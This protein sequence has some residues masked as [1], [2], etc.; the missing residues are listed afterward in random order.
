M[1]IRL[2][3]GRVNFYR[4]CS[5]QYCWEIEI[6]LFVGVGTARFTSAIANQGVAAVL[7]VVIAGLANYFLQQQRIR[8]MQQESA[9][10]EREKRTAETLAAGQTRRLADIYAASG[11]ALEAEGDYA[12]ALLWFSKALGEEP[13]DSARAGTHRQRLVS[14][15]QRM[16]SMPLLLAHAGGVNSAAFSHDGRRMVTASDDRTAQVWDAATGEPIGPPLN[17]SNRVLHAELSADGG[18]V[19]TLNASGLA[20]LWSQLGSAPTAASLE[21][22][23]RFTLVAFSPNGRQLMT[24]TDGSEAL[25]WETS[26]RRWRFKLKHAGRILCAAFSADGRFVATGGQDQSARVWNTDTG[27]LITTAMEPEGEV[28]HLAFSPDGRRLATAAGARARIWS[29]SGGDA[30]LFLLH[31]DARV[32]S[33]GFSPEGSRILTSS[34]D[35]SA[36]Q[37]DAITGEALGSPARHP[38]AVRQAVFSPDGRCIATAC[39][40]RVQVWN[41]RT[42]KLIPPVFIHNAPV[43]EVRFSPSGHGLLTASADGTARWF[44]LEAGLE[45]PSAEESNRPSSTGRDSGPKV[46][47]PRGALTDEEWARWAQACSGRHVS[48]AEQIEPLPAESLRK[49]W[50]LLREKSPAHFDSPDRVLWH[51]RAAEACEEAG[52]WFGANFHWAQAL[53]LRPGEARFRAGRERAA[54]QQALLEA[55]ASAE[56]GTRNAERGI[57]DSALTVPRSAFPLAARAG[58]LDLSSHYNAAL[59]KT[60]LPNRLA[61][62][63]PLQEAINAGYVLY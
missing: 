48:S 12:G 50:V 42:F 53:T 19:L 62:S 49:L 18:R 55:K 60:W 15:R 39:G 13:S 10:R 7:V 37:W 33:L 47:D 16:P 6:P 28:T 26:S 23:G 14:L 44:A 61:A 4:V 27:Q 21:Y 2:E 41:A 11:Q 8:R 25:L 3:A 31:H 22:D 57:S 46:G 17:H 1:T 24:V 59:G 45:S 52:D 32:M 63:G 30:A 43:R 20:Q 54:R 38:G 29:A 40:E 51:P 56:R 58:L 5:R 36:R 34:A 35:L 9:Q